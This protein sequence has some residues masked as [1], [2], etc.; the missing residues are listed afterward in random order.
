VAVAVRS[1]GAGH[2]L[3]L[4]TQPCW[5]VPQGSGKGAC[6]T[7]DGV[8]SASSAA[9]PARS[10]VPPSCKGPL[11]RRR[12]PRL[13]GWRSF[14]RGHTHSARR[15]LQSHAPP[16]PPGPTTGASASPPHVLQVLQDGG[17]QANPP[18]TQPLGDEESEPPPHSAP[19][20]AGHGPPQWTPALLL[21]CHAAAARGAQCCV[22]GQGGAATCEGISI[23]Q[24]CSTNSPFAAR[25]QTPTRTRT[26]APGSQPD[27]ASPLLAPPASGRWRTDSGPAKRHR[28]PA[29]SD[30]LRDR[31]P[32][33]GRGRRCRPAICEGGMLE[34]AAAC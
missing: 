21:P 24:F 18:H 12:R 30:Y 8:A 25:L 32:R 2:E 15:L 6:G 20:V 13:A 26:P 31:A 34:A 5:P 29:H 9:A 33:L 14:L 23:Y 1:T 28:P 10:G 3:L 16:G 17:R 4:Q 7:A 27:R 11:R 19:P 22:V